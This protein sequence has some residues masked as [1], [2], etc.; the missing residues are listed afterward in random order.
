[1]QHGQ[2]TALIFVKLTNKSAVAGPVH[3]GWGG[4]V[5]M[6]PCDLS[7]DV[8]VRIGIYERPDPIPAS[9]RIWIEGNALK[10]VLL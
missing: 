2:T 10:A 5:A 4:N 8:L 9:C 7:Y 3:W 6:L 1:M